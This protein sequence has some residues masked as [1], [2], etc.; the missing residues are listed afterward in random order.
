MLARRA[1]L[2]AVISILAIAVSTIWAGVAH[3]YSQ[4][5]IADNATYCGEC[6]GDFRSNDYIS[7]VDGENWGNLHDLH[8][9]TMLNRDCETC[10]LAGDEFPVMLNESAGGNGLAP[11]SCMGCHGVDPNPGTPNSN[12]GAG[13][14]LHHLNAGVRPDRNDEKCDACHQN[15][16]T[17]PAESVLPAFYF[18]PDAAHP[19][20]PTDPCNPAPDLPEHFAGLTLGM[21]NDGDLD[22]DQVDSDCALFTDGFESGDT[23]GWASATP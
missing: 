9:E 20:K 14:R 1:D 16:P 23:S 8:R 22:Y 18:T 17:P 7:P 21:D 13:L 15:D 11:V 4:W 2:I 3:A 5:S 6:H 19:N 10:H 12:W